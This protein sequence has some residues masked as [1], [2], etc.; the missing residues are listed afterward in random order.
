MYNSTA[1]SQSCPGGA[2]HPVRYRLIFLIFL[3]C[4]TVSAAGAVEFLP[5][6]FK[7]E[8]VKATIWDLNEQYVRLV[9]IESGAAPNDHPVVLDKTEVDQALASLELWIE[10]GLLRDEEAVK[11]Y[12][13]KQASSSLVMSPR[14]WARRHRTRMSRSTC[15]ATRT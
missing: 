9:D 6:L 11:L 1:D 2:M 10:G 14:P 7:K 4:A 3:S 8:K 5:D 13:R 15:G 12:P